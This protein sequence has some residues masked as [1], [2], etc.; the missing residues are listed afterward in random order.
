MSSSFSTSVPGGDDHDDDD[1]DDTTVA[2]QTRLDKKRFEFDWAF[3]PFWLLFLTFVP[4]CYSEP[5]HGEEGE[6]RLND[7]IDQWVVQ[8]TS[9]QKDKKASEV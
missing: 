4:W 7:L 8:H 2:M 3:F 9:T 5:A 1:D 6:T